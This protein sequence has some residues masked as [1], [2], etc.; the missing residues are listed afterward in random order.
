[1]STDKR[2]I[3]I[4]GRFRSGTSFLWQLFD[5]L[6]GYCAWYEPLHPQ[7]LTAIHYVTPKEDHVGVKDYWSAYRQHPSFANKYSSD[8]ATQH[9]YLEAKKSVPRFGSLHQA[10]HHAF[11]RS[12]TGVAIQSG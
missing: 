11:W 9:V 2:P 7:L 8:F 1:M 5:Q 6:E 4:T 10:P 3:F 12:S